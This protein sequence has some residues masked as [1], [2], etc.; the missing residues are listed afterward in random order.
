MRIFFKS[1]AVIYKKS[2][3][4]SVA[5]GGRTPTGELTLSVS[6]CGFPGEIIP[7]FSTV[8]VYKEEMQ[9]I[10]FLKRVFRTIENEV[11][12]KSERSFDN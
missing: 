2:T 6:S 1:V 5:V 3:K 9:Y 12:F 10:V 7:F 11:Q 4:Q 8:V